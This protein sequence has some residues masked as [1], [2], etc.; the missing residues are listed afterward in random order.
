MVSYRITYILQDNARSIKYLI[1]SL[2]RSVKPAPGSG[3]NEKARDRETSKVVTELMGLVLGV[4]VANIR[5]SC[6]RFDGKH[7]VIQNGR[8]LEG[9]LDPLGLFTSPDCSNKRLEFSA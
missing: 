2:P 4:L 6:G 3:I 9:S 5:L 8:N 1:T 7:H